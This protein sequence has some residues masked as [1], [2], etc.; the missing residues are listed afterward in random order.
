MAE[1]VRPEV[2]AVLAAGSAPAIGAGVEAS[3]N[4]ADRSS[5]TGTGLRRREIVLLLAGTLG[6]ALAYLVPMV[7][8][9]ALKLDILVPGN[10][11]SLGYMIGAGSVVTLITAPLTG[12]LSDRARSRWG[13]RRPFTVAG[14]IL[15]LTATTV[16][17]TAG[18][19]WL[20][21]LGW[22][23]ANLGWG[24]AMGS[25]GNIQADRLAPSQR[26]TVGAFTGVV[27]Q[28]APVAGILL[29]GPVASDVALAMWLPVVVGFPLIVLF[30]CF[31]REED[32]RGAVFADRL[33]VGMLV[34]SYGFRP[35]EF[36]DFAWNWAGRFLFFAGITFTSTYS[37]FFL[38]DRLELSV[39]GI[40]PV[41][42]L[43]SSIGIVVST[44]GAIGS[45]W[46]SDRAGRRRP[47][48]LCAV[49]L[50]AVG[51]SVSALAPALPHLI[52]GGALSSLGVAVFLAINQAMVLDVLP[53]RE[54]QAG[55]FM[56][57]TAFSQ[58]IPNAL[59]PLLAP[60][61]LSAGGGGNYALLYLCAG[62]LVLLG[63]VLI[64]VKVS[65]V[66]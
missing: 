10:E 32:S 42:A 41:V 33:T 59:A 40:A 60:V 30:L 58:K 29:I 6:S 17:A 18:D 48:V 52:I 1:R 25:I 44:L 39:E 19:V 16:M 64:V 55:R 51:A 13:R 8:T 66:R 20:L 54:T 12:V 2:P 3:A 45:G 43:M 14:T 46:M 24:T 9:L 23:L 53:H 36:P 47:F 38:A 62:G 26:G 65:G 35:R 27:T 61:L 31:I 63:G 57:I 28:M 22:V 37:T 11:S 5:A 21:G 49:L 50:F 34:R 15:G 7:F 4:P 56:G